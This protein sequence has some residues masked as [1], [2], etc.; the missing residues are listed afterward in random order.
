MARGL[1]LPMQV[2]TIIAAGGFDHQ[3][4]DAHLQLAAGLGEVRRQPGIACTAS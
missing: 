3:G 1:S 4:V 2:S